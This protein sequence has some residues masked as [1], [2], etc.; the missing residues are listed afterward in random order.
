MCVYVYMDLLYRNWGLE[1][2]LKDLLF[3]YLGGLG[4]IYLVVYCS[5]LESILVYYS[6]L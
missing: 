3:G 4:T 5:I 6:L 2:A 1:G